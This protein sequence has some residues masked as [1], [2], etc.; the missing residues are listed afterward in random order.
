MLGS[1]GTFD[2]HDRA[3]D[4]PGLRRRAAGPRGG[5][6]A[7]RHPPA[8]QGPRRAPHPGAARVVSKILVLV[9]D[10]I[11]VEYPG[12]DGAPLRRDVFAAHRSGIGATPTFHGYA[13]VN[14]NDPTDVKTRPQGKVG[15]GWTLIL[16]GSVSLVVGFVLL[17]V[18]LAG[19]STSTSDLLSQDGSPGR[20][21]PV[22]RRFRGV[23]WL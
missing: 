8:A 19:M 13:Y 6:P 21:G 20:R 17:M 4:L 22:R 16:V 15:P 11:T 3:A 18:A 12:P 7:R 10:I 2:P 5:R 1:S 14:R 23:R 9:G